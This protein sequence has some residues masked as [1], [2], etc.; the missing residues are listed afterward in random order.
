MRALAVLTLL[1]GLGFAGFVAW[2]TGDGSSLG[3]AAKGVAWALTVAGLLTAWLAL[4]VATSGRADRSF[5][6][7]VVAIL[8]WCAA[9]AT[10]MAFA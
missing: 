5:G 7:V 9:F 10:A 2:A 3:E 1:G 4:V 6:L 8:T